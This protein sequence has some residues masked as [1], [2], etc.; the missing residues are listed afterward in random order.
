MLIKMLI[1]AVVLLLA[2]FLVLVWLVAM[3]AKVTLWL[4]ATLTACVVLSAA[5][6]FLVRRLRASRAASGLEEGLKEQ[7]KQHARQARPDV[8]PELHQMQESFDRAVT[9]LKNS[10][11]GR[12][13]GSDAL[14]FLPWY[15]IIGPSGAGKTTALRHSGLKF[16]PLKG[17]R[18]AKVRGLGG[19]RNCD[20]WLTNQAVLLDTAGRWATQEEDH[21]E[22]LGFL[23]MLKKYRP[24]KPLNGVIAAISLGDIVNVAE[25]EV[26]SIAQRMR[27]RVDEII[28][29]LHVSI[30]VYVLFT[31][32]DLIEGFV[33]TFGAMPSADRDQ[34]WGFTAA[35]SGDVDEAGVYFEQQF[36]ELTQRLEAISLARI[37]A[38]RSIEARQLIYAFPQQVM[39]MRQNL[40]RFMSAMF[41]SNVYQE[42]PRLRG[43]YF[44]SGTQEGRP[45]NMLINRLADALGIS[46]AA[47]EGE[48]AIVDQKSY[49]LR[50][51]FLK[52]I[53]EDQDLASAS[54]K[55]LRRDRFQQ[56]AVTG[57]LAVVALALGSVPSFAFFKNRRQ[58][59]ETASLV[60]YWERPAAKGSAQKQRIDSLGRVLQDLASYELNEPGFATTLGM[61]QGDRVRP[62][63]RRYTAQLLRRE[64]VGPLV[65]RDLHAMTEFGFKYETAPKAVPNSSEQGAY[66]GMVKQHLLL[67]VPRAAGEPGLNQEQAAWM[68]GQLAA[69]LPGLFE[70]ASPDEETF[71]TLAG[72]YVEYAIEYPELAFARDANVIRRA[73]TALTRVPLTRQALERIIAQVAEEDY[74]LDLPRLIGE[75]TAITARQSVRGAFTRR[76][77]ENVVREELTTDAVQHAGELW[78]LGEADRRDTRR[79]ADAQLQE[80]ASLYFQSYAEEWRA[81]LNGLRVKKPTSNSDALLLL[82]ELLRGTPPPLALL[83]QKVDQNLQLKPA[84]AAEA[85]AGSVATG[86]KAKVTSLLGIDEDKPAAQVARKLRDGLA[87]QENRMTPAKVAAMFRGFTSFAVAASTGEADGAALAVPYGSY[88]EQLSAVRDILRMEAD[89]PQ[90]PERLANGLQA[91]QLRVRTL[92]DGRDPAWHSVFEALLEPPI[93]S[94]AA[95]SNR[96]VADSTG[97]RWCSEVA[98]PFDRNIRDKYPFDRRGHDLPLESF[99]SLYKPNEGAIWRF[100]RE[101]LS[102]VVQLDGDDYKFGKRPGR[103]ASSVYSASLPQFL[104]RSRELSALFFPQGEGPKID[105]E[106]R[107]HPAPGVAT[108]LFSIGGQSI[109]YHNGPERWHTVSW[110]GKD[111][112]AGA[113]FLARGGNGMQERAQHEGAWGLFR[114][115]EA[116]TITRP[117]SQLFTVGWQLRTHDVTL[118]IDFRP[119]HTESPFFGDP[120]RGS[121]AL[122]LLQPLRD[123]DAAAPK[124]ITHAGHPCDT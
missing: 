59:I 50:D 45:F 47:S 48:A 27:E 20:W 102:N 82:N 103:D 39:A 25:D 95:T 121:G 41:E 4:P 53:F 104:S 61:Y 29:Q 33:E 7:A 81:F 117:S 55:K 91:A 42:T 11:H 22:W 58:L 99:S 72:R 108:T 10:P 35:I 64:L 51:V 32:C 100:T 17:T 38:E 85:L 65:A 18:D 90:S 105:F 30:P 68:S 26:D 76:G 84:P 43:V 70:A 57:V 123:R 28:G 36:E 23:S 52:V 74:D 62:H 69:R 94:A 97:R 101:A 1:A 49:F 96:A 13:R 16:P 15:T 78:V 24:R 86:L 114:L 89:D 60:D 5:V 67:T 73:R 124:Q 110:P 119:L 83:I 46:Q 115:F 21:D 9:A 77:W 6:F 107:V 106:V 113:G 98:E 31:K 40:S 122:Q 56:H 3:L 63:L 8:E 12:R 120:R 54:K 66:Y 87:Q 109:E 14:Y 92:I 118:K 111:P 79:Q 75:T 112:Q 88:Q 34:V 116:G 44:T 80:L 37:G 93:E 71:K 19:T 2:M